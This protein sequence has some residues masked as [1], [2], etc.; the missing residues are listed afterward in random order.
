MS[1]RSERGCA[2]FRRLLRRGFLQVGALG[3]IGLT[4]PEYLRRLSA[5]PAAQVKAR[6]ERTDLFQQSLH[7]HFREVVSRKPG[8]S[9][10]RSAEMYLV[11][12]GLKH[13]T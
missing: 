4:L 2:E 7:Q 11:G 9:R 6:S 3:A 8:A 1:Q 10:E 12:K 13:K 5:A